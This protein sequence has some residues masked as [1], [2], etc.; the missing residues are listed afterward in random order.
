MKI[1]KFFKF[2]T[3]ALM[4]IGI[5]A[6]TGCEPVDTTPDCEKYHYGSVTVINKTGY[7]IWVNVTW[8]SSEYN[9]EKMLYNGGNTIYYEVP[10]GSIRIW[11]SFDGDNW[12]Y[13]NNYLSDCEEL[14]YTWYLSAKKS[15]TPE[16]R[17][18]VSNNGD[19]IK[20]IDTFIKSEKLTQ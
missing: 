13:D 12:Q 6:F 7:K 16:L 11:G 9:N 4:F 8:G 17:L 14:R 5:I 10:S 1:K 3:L 18:E 2:A 19:I 20:T 15:T